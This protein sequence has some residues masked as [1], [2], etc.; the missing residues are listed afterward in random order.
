MIHAPVSCI[1]SKK[2]PCFC[3]NFSLTGFDTIQYT[4]LEQEGE[5]FDNRT[6]I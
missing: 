3:K 6:G 1:N 5:R 2:Y 4:Y